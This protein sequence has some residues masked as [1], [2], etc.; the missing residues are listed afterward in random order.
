MSKTINRSALQNKLNMMVSAPAIMDKLSETEMNKEAMS[1]ITNYAVST[2][3]RGEIVFTSFDMA[4]LSGYPVDRIRKG[5]AEFGIGVATHEDYLVF[6]ISNIELLIENTA[7]D[8]IILETR[9]MMVED[10]AS[11]LV[12]N[13]ITNLSNARVVCLDLTDTKEIVNP[14]TDKRETTTINLLSID[15]T[16]VFANSLENANF[17]VIQAEYSLTITGFKENQ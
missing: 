3:K 13:I 9:D 11:L 12:D 5:L 2:I 7:S 16:T 17:N 8:P 1:M 14:Y 6:T 4:L 10:I 15:E